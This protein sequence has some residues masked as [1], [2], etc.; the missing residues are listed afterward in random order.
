ML[1]DKINCKLTYLISEIIKL[2]EPFWTKTN[3]NFTQAFTSTD[4]NYPKLPS[5]DCKHWA[6]FFLLLFP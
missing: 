6:S 4:C 2:Q 1:A 5:T 3:L